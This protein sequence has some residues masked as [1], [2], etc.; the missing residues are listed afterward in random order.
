MRQQSNIRAL[1][2]HTDSDE[3][4]RRLPLTFRIDGKAVPS[5]AV[6][7]A[8]RALQGVGGLRL[9]FLAWDLGAAG[10]RV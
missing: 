1:N 5:M 6:E 10:P 4:I 2:V 9:R 7:L 3:V 8:S